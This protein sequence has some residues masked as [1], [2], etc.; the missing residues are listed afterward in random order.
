MK[1]NRKNI[2]RMSLA[3]QVLLVAVLIGLDMANVIDGVF[4]PFVCGLIVI[5]CLSNLL[6]KKF[7]PEGARIE[8]EA[9]TLAEAS[10]QTVRVSPSI[11][12]YACDLATVFVLVA[13]WALAAKRGVIGNNE[14]GFPEMA[15]FTL[16]CL[17]YLVMSY[18]PKTIGGSIGVTG[19]KQVKRLVLRSHALALSSSLVILSTVLL[20]TRPAN[21]VTEALAVISVALVMV[22]F[23]WKFFFK[24]GTAVQEKI[25]EL[26]QSNPNQQ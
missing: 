20:Y 2:D 10:K 15:A 11:A 13:A 23:C 5:V 16:L 9:E 24:R 21:P 25:E 22:L 12:G 18:L 6:K 17:I 3:A 26:E 7:D 8:A 4:L 19:M 14:M 1:L